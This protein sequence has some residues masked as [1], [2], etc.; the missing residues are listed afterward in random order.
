[1]TIFWSEVRPDKCLGC[2][3]L[4]ADGHIHTSLF[5]F[6]NLIRY[7]WG[8][9]DATPGLP[10]K[11]FPFPAP[12]LQK[13]KCS[14]D[15]KKPNCGGHTVPSVIFPFCQRKPCCFDRESHTVI[16]DY[17]LITA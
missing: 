6:H 9:A 1:M 12:K 4:S 15:A 10:G 7:T 14:A 17:V 5:F 13:F 3:V 11:N 8:D 2:S 16:T